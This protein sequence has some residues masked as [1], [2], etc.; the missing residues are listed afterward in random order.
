M[1]QSRNLKKSCKNDP[2]N[3]ARKKMKLAIVKLTIEPTFQMLSEVI[4]H[5]IPSGKCSRPSVPS[6][7]QLLLNCM[8]LAQY[9]APDST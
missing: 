6:E 1:A 5:T 2:S 4:F 8:Y 7:F 3:V 9:R